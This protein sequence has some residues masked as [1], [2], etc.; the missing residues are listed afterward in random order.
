MDYNNFNCNNF[1]IRN[2]NFVFTHSVLY[3]TSIM[4]SCSYVA[5]T[6]ACL[7]L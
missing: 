1:V 6:I 5:D 7:K 4:Q 3:Q 2:N